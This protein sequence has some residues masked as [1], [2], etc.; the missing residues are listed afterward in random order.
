M[1]S[2][3]T[4][5]KTYCIVYTH[6]P[7]E[8]EGPLKTTDKRAHQCESLEYGMNTFRRISNYSGI[9]EVCFKELCS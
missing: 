4:Y 7:L 8:S 3:L 6:K 9:K 1:R 2:N 5:N